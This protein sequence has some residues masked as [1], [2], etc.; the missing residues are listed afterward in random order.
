MS[1]TRFAGQ[2]A[3]RV[4]P[5]RH[6]PISIFER[7]ARPEDIE[8]NL[9]LEMAFS[10]HHG[11]AM[12]ILAL[13]REDW[14]TGPGSGFIMAPFVYPSPSRFTDGSFGV[15][16]A[17]LEER[18]AIEEVAW[19]RERFMAST[20]QGPMVLDHHVLR[21]AFGG[22][23][24][25]LRGPDAP[26]P[27]LLDPDPDRY[28]AAQAWAKARRNEG[29]DGIAYPSVRKAGGQCAALFRP[30]AVRSCR[31][32]KQLHYLWNGSRIVGW[33]EGRDGVR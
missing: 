25:D 14:A 22:D 24:V 3:W 2:S 11:E 18:T 21:A 7:A 28:P 6:P 16:Y 9:R 10:A 20:G 27:A 29:L 23:L 1:R 33:S 30:R 12:R 13:P 31:V 4:V 5:T 26:P 15:F 8:D 19:H 17:G 32:M